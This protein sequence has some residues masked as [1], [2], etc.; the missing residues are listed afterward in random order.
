[1]NKYTVLGPT[2]NSEETLQWQAF[3]IAALICYARPFLRSHGLHTLRNELLENLSIQ[4]KLSHD[5]F[6]DRRN[7][8]IAHSDSDGFEIQA[9]NINKN[10]MSLHSKDKYLNKE[11]AEELRLLVSE[12]LTMV[13][14]I[15]NNHENG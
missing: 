2:N 5:K 9:H 12:M 1:L 4:R 14:N 3:S 7:K 11:E 10:A 15:R 6:I 13:Q 8:L